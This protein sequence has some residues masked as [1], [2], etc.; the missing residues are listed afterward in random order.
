MSRVT[1][2]ALCACAFIAFSVIANARSI[3]HANPIVDLRIARGKGHI[4]E[5]WFADPTTRYRHFVLG[6]NYEPETLVV[7]L[8]SGKLLKISAGQDAVFEDRQPR[9]ADLDGDG[10]DEIVVVK[11]YLSRGAA[12]AIVTIRDGE[13]KIIA[14]TDATGRP[15][16]WLNPAGI[17]DFDGDGRPEI[18]YV[19]MPHVLGLLKVMALRGDRLVEIARIAGISNHVLG[20]SRIGMAAVVDFDRDDIADLAIPSLDRGTIRVISFR[21]GP[22]E[23]R[24]VSLG[25]KAVDDFRVALRGKGTSVISIPLEDGRIFELLTPEP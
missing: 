2:S 16:T 13:L 19:Q 17:A 20:S 11:T 25:G 22:R 3:V 6:S 7:K 8:R 14:E 9:L 4:A 5:V 1:V 18:A 10:Q 23:I 24:R 15:N 21:G 12:L